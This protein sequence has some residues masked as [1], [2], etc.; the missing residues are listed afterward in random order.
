VAVYGCSI[1]GAGDLGCGWGSYRGWGAEE[2]VMGRVSVC[3]DV[4]MG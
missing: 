1:V 2:G 3:M 4:Q